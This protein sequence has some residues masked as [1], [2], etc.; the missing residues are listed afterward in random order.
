MIVKLYLHLGG[1]GLGGGG[2]PEHALGVTNTSDLALL[3][4]LEGESGDEGSTDT[5]TVLSGED[6]DR[7]VALTESLAIAAAV[8]VEDLLERLRTTGLEVGVLRAC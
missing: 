4:T 8:P 7:V 6:L 2:T 3:N 5:G 1:A